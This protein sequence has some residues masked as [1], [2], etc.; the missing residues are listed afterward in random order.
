MN[1]KCKAMKKAA[2]MAL[3]A[4]TTSSGLYADGGKNKNRKKDKAKIECCEKSTCNKKEKA[5]CCENKPA[6]CTQKD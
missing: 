5:G 1:L 2:L 4:L 3:L 6:C